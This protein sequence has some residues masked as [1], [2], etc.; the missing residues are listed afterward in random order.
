MTLVRQLVGGVL[1]QPRFKDMTALEMLKKIY[2]FDPG[3]CRHC[4]GVHLKNITIPSVP[5]RE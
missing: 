1:M 2:A 5:K 4:G 3:V